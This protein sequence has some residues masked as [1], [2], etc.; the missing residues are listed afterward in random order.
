[1]AHRTKKF[2]ELNKEH[3]QT[4]ATEMRRMHKKPSVCSVTQIILAAEAVN[5][6]FRK[7]LTRF[8]SNQVQ[9][10]LLD[11]LILHDGVMRATDMSRLTFRSKVAI[12]KAIDNLEKAGLVKR[13][14]AE[15]DRREKDIA[16]TEKGVRLISMT[17]GERWLAHNKIAS[18][19]DD[20]TALDLINSLKQVRRHT[21]SLILSKEE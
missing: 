13:G 5:E 16:I 8:F 10:R 9:F 4:L 2:S 20:K 1:M 17:M 19:F 11:A 18:C 14:P 12:T 3:M 15:K 7:E 21:R 6:Y